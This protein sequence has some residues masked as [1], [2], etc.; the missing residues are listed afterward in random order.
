MLSKKFETTAWQVFLTAG[1]METESWEMYLFTPIFSILVI[2][3][4]LMLEITVF[5]QTEMLFLS[6]CL[7]FFLTSYMGIS[8]LKQTGLYKKQ[9]S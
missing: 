4:S 8:F 6:V 3:L 9:S 1:A 7:I 2:H 5:G